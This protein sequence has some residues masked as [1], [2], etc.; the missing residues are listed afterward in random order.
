MSKLRVGCS[1]ITQ[2]I[3]AGR[4]DN[5]GELWVGQKHD[6]T[7]DVLGAVIAKVGAGNILTIN[8]NGKP[9]FEIEVRE[10][11]ESSHD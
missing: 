2:T 6:V 5:K 7:S 8:E 1:S 10:I 9:K 4:L 11:K 3:Y